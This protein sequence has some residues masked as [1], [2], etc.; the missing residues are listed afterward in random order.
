MFLRRIQCGIQ[1][2]TQAPTKTV[3]FF[4]SLLFFRAQTGDRQVP[5]PFPHAET[6]RDL[7]DTPNR[8][9]LLDSSP[10][11]SA[12]LPPRPRCRLRQIAASPTLAA[13]AGSIP[14]A[15]RRRLRV[16]PLPSMV[17]FSAQSS[18]TL[19]FSGRAG[20]RG[21]GTPR[22]RCAC[23]SLSGGRL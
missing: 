2:S 14:P 21:F 7:F 5:L 18:S 22:P 19:G 3:V 6:R 17:S 8:R 15:S 12:P 13:P 4:F 10:L 16:A 9:R 1:T 20:G 11:R 23:S